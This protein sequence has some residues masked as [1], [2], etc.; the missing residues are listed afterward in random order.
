MKD[1]DTRS[2]AVIE[3]WQNREYKTVN[4]KMAALQVIING[5]LEEQNRL[6]RMACSDA[7]SSIVCKSGFFI[8]EIKDA[9]EQVEAL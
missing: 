3:E 7:A 2:F 9:C 1:K 4:Q 8:S 6:T 5:A